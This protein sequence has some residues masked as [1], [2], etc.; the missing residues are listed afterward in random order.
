M[1]MVAVTDTLQIAVYLILFLR[2]RLIFLNFVLQGLLHDIIVCR[3]T[4]SDKIAAISNTNWHDLGESAT[5][6]E[7][8]YY[9]F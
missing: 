6:M 3:T 8:L 1:D 5:K 9:L 4:R 2:G 7:T